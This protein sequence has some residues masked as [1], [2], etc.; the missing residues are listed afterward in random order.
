MIPAA[1]QCACLQNIDAPFRPLCAGA[2]ASQSGCSGSCVNI[3]LSLYGESLLPVTY[4]CPHGVSHG[5]CSQCC[6]FGNG[7]R[8]RLNLKTFCGFCDP[9]PHERLDGYA[10]RYKACL[11]DFEQYVSTLNEVGHAIV[12]EFSRRLGTKVARILEPW[13]D[14]AQARRLSHED[15]VYLSQ[16]RRLQRRLQQ[17]QEGEQTVVSN[18]VAAIV[19]TV[20]C[21]KAECVAAKL[22][23]ASS[24]GMPL[25]ECR[26]LNG[27]LLA[28]FQMRLLE[29]TVK[30]L[31]T[32]LLLNIHEKRYLDIRIDKD[33]NGYSHTEFVER[34]GDALGEQ[35]WADAWPVLCNVQ[36]VS[37]SGQRLD[38]SD[39]ILADVL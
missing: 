8:N 15:A 33:F 9:Q 3:R 34:Y 1:S 20:C 36:L 16:V 31:H 10:Q 28:S 11:Q 4:A 21:S 5:H 17:L 7:V 38:N 30:Q 18:P 2:A 29:T 37:Q 25:L 32:A 12:S 6:P 14:N 24:Q 27:D 39:V 22:K 35:R 19:V 13:A 26:S 23:L